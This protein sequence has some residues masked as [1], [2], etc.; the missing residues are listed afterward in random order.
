MN[1]LQRDT[2]LTRVLSRLIDCML[3]SI[4]WLFTSIPVVTIGASTTA[5]YSVALKLAAGEHP[6]LVS[7]Y[8]AAF[9]KNILRSTAVF[10][11]LTGT[12]LF[13]GLDLWCVLQWETPF[14]FALEVLILSVGFFYLILATHAF[15]ALAFY[16]GKP[17]QILKKVFFRSLSKGIYTVFVVVLSVFPP[18]FLARRAADSSFGQWLMLFL[19]VGNGVICYFN[20][21]H[22]VRLFDPERAEAAAG[23]SVEDGE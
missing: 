15:P 16:E 6:A 20:S 13:I 8:F 18:L 11:A 21:L 3:L 12:G 14:Q 2:F 19:L 9:K 22:L 17:A 23:E 5:A 7:G 10:L 4:L 1:F